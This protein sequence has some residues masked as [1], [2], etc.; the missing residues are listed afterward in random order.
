VETCTYTYI[1]GTCI[2]SYNICTCLH[3]YCRRVSIRGMYRM[4]H[5]SKHMS[6]ACCHHCQIYTSYSQVHMLYSMNTYTCRF[7]PF[8]QERAQSDMYRKRALAHFVCGIPCPNTHV[9][10][11]C[12]IHMYIMNPH[13]MCESLWIFMTC[14]YETYGMRHMTMRHMN[15]RHT[16]VSMRHM[17]MIARI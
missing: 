4:E 2:V 3:T 10:F 9:I 1:V 8:L 17:L 14:E 13:D 11:R 12:L 16:L 5:M 6:Y 7:E 15:M